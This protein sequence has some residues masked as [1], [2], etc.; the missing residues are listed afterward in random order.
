VETT[1][2][3]F[4]SRRIARLPAGEEVSKARMSTDA[5]IGQFRG[6]SVQNHVFRKP[7]KVLNFDENT[8]TRRVHV[9]KI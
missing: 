7:L 8:L 9:P 3:T 4:S 1:P 5:I 6:Q 2:M